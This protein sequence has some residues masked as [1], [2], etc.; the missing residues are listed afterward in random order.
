M[1]RIQA[2]CMKVWN[3]EAGKK[4]FWKSVSLLCDYVRPVGKPHFFS[5]RGARIIAG[6]WNRHH[7]QD[8]YDVL[9]KIRDGDITTTA[10]I[11]DQFS[12]IGYFECKTKGDLY[13]RIKFISEQCK[14]TMPAYGMHQ[15]HAV[16][17]SQSL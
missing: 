11:L 5:D 6:H 9:R 7:I 2:E 12:I 3:G 1:S 10:G 16:S 8:V 14:V 13:L 4:D 17:V 15:V